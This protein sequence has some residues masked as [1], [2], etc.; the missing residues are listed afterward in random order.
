MNTKIEGRKEIYLE[1]LAQAHARLQAAIQGLDETVM[2]TQVVTGDWTIKDLLGHMVSWN[3][4]FRANIVAIL[5]GEHP[6]T[7]HTISGV[8][9]FAAWNQAWYLGKK[10][11]PLAEILAD[12]T[13]DYWEGRTLINSLEP[14]DYRKRGVTP[15]KARPGVV[16][17]EPAKEDTD[18]VETL[19]TFHWRHMNQHL[20]EIEH[21]R[22]S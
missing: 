15:W 7:D 4:E 16:S 8:D 13:A 18:T 6:G 10:D 21:W 17:D 14:G 12:V 2:C 19:V 3:Q 11:R 5:R 22:G 20:R 9:D 1:R